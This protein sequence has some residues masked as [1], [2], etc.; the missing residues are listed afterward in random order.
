MSGNA[1]VCGRW[2]LVGAF[3][4]CMTGSAVHGADENES[5]SAKPAQSTV[6]LDNHKK[7]WAG[8]GVLTVAEL[9]E[10]LGPA[11]SIV[12][13]NRLN[14]NEDMSMIWEDVS[15]IQIEFINGSAVRMEGMFSPHIQS[16]TIHFENFKKLEAGMT[17]ADIEEILGSP[18]TLNQP[19]SEKITRT[20]EKYNRLTVRIAGDKVSS[21][22]WERTTDP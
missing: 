6:T 8:K 10:M 5:G 20:W 22:L 19:T 12:K 16:E 9:L 7:I 14:T 1:F 13:P 2:L 15:R 3:S 21:S 18:Q 4:L 11:A 17:A